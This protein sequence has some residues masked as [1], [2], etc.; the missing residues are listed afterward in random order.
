MSPLQV[1]VVDDYPDS[2]ELVALVLEQVGYRVLLATNGPHALALAKRHLP[3]AIVMDLYMPNMDGIA[4]TRLLRADPD[5]TYIP[6]VAYTARADGMAGVEDL[7]DELCT[8]PCSPETLL[9][10]V[11]RAIRA[12]RPQPVGMAPPS[13]T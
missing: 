5:L 1:L 2:L 8:K 4:T 11:E 12:R 13:D 9:A 3:A 10:V 7:F 6:V